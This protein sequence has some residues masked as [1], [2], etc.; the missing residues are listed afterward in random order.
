MK[1]NKIVLIGM[2]GSGKSTVSKLLSEKLNLSL[3]DTDEIF[4]QQEKCKIVDFFKK[5]GEE[6][7][8]EIESEI[9][10]KAL[11][12]SNCIISTGGGIVLKEENRILLSDKSILTIYLSTNYETIY[13][14]IKDDKTRPL[15]L[16]EN[17]KEEI[18]KILNSREQFYNQA[19]ITIETDNKTQQEIAEEILKIYG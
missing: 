17:P 3:L 8:R 16:V 15:L 11:T 14:R 4:E 10:K 2:M 6:K 5:Y 19:K 7:F 1:Y 18:K 9:L 13:N 12:K